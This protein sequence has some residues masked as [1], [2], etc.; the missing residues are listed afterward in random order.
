MNPITYPARPIN[1]GSLNKARPKP[2]QWFYEP[3]YNGWRALIHV[4]TGTMFNRQLQRLS[5]AKEFAVA[6]DKLKQTHFEW[7]DCEALERRH[8]IGRGSLI[9]L[10]DPLSKFPYS[11]KPGRLDTLWN[12][13]VEPGLA[14]C[15]ESFS[16]DATAGLPGSARTVL[17]FHC[18]R[19][20]PDSLYIP[21]AF[22]EWQARSIWRRQ[23]LQQV[24]A[25]L[26]CDFYEGLVAKQADAPYP[27]QLRSPDQ[28]TTAWI[29]HRWQF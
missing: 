7:L 25:R 13:L 24:N 6:L 14:Q 15:L 4:P 29:K 22:L 12:H 23:L 20:E 27:V 21:S 1:G 16:T 10:D 3:K 8:D 19:P 26:R 11:G 28:E 5:I 17:D 18:R 2:G 9:V